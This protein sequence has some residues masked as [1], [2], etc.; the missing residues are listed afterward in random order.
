MPGSHEE[1]VLRAGLRLINQVKKNS[2]ELLHFYCTD[3]KTLEN[4][5]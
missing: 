4:Q 1:Q 3:E 5:W 2:N